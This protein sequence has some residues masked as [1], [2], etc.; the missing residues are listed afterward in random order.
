MST[1]ILKQTGCPA[2]LE[3]NIETSTLV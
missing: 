3:V 1:I 2:A